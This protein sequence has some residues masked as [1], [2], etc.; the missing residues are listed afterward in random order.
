DS[1]P[2]IDH[3]NI[4][5]LKSPS[6]LIYDFSSLHDLR[7][8]AR[9]RGNITLM[10]ISR[11]GETWKRYDEYSHLMRLT[12]P[13]LEIPGGASLGKGEIHTSPGSLTSFSDKSVSIA[14]KLAETPVTVPVTT[15][16]ST[17]TT[18]SAMIAKAHILPA[19]SGFTFNVPSFLI[20]L[21]AGAGILFLLVL[22]GVIRLAS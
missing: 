17:L 21:F 14:Q 11:D 2:S 9:G 18:Q 20:G 1:T 13:R 22:F 5:K 8:W 10:Q 6:G 3:A 15:R 19:E 7:K 4:W 12:A 16:N